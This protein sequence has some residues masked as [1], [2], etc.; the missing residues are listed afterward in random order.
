MDEPGYKDRQ[1]DFRKENI[2]M[3]RKISQSNNNYEAEQ[4]YDGLM[5]SIDEEM[6]R[7]GHS[8]PPDNL[9][10]TILKEILKLK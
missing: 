2:E 6:R 7:S 4:K 9:M 1:R 10:Y 3:L 5:K 8:P